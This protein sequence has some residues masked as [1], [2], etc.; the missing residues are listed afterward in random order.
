MS[1]DMP[2]EMR[3][4]PSTKPGSELAVLGLMGGLLAVAGIVVLVIGLNTG[5]DPSLFAEFDIEDLA[6]KIALTVAGVGMG[7]VGLMAII[8][9]MVASTL[10][11]AITDPSR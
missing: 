7:V 10:R 6:Q 11:T 2:A 5:N 9:A 1:D 4:A 3:S 8:C